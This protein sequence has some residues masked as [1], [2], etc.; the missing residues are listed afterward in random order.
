MTLV[1][2]TPNDPASL[3]AELRRTLTSIN[4]EIPLS[5][6]LTLR[7]VVAQSLA[8]PRSTMALFTI[9]AALALLLG[10]VGVYGV[11]SYGVAQ[12]LPEIGMRIALG[13]QK[14]DVMWLVM[15][16][17]GRLGLI[18]VSIGIAG[19]IVGTRLI[20]SLLFAV[21]ATDLFTYSV[22]SLLLILVTLAAC[23]IPAR[24]ATKVDP[25]MALR[26]E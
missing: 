4:S 1:V 24:R 15:E 26:H 9:F 16:Q 23:Y 7:T 11:I 2:R 12:R 25:M 13:A 8:A 19:A 20:S 17:G 14:L 5:E 18:G 21:S 6:I 22:V 10:A 3:S